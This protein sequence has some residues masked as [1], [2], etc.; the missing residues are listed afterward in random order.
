VPS[1][2]WQ[3]YLRVIHQESGWQDVLDRSG[4]NTVIVDRAVRDGL[5]RALKD[6]PKWRVG[7]EDHVATV[8]VRKQPI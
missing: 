3:S 5:I 1:E 7:Y 4:V 6:D 8:F 2:V